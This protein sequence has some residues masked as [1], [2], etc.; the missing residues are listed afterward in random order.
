MLKMIYDGD[1]C[2]RQIRK[3]QLPK[4]KTMT[5]YSNVDNN[6]LDISNRSLTYSKN[7]T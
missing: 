6:H 5:P 1:L 3:I 4:F 7:S 2:L